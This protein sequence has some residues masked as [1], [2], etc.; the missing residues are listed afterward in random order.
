MTANA[1]DS[2][3]PKELPGITQRK[4]GAIFTR[5]ELRMLNERS[6]WRGLAAVGFTW[7]VILATAAALVWARSQPALIAVPVFVLGLAVLGGRHLGLAVLHHEAAHRSLFKTPW[8]NEVVGD[9]V[10]A[11]PVWNDLKK[12]RVHHFIHHRKT[13]QPEDTDRSL[14]EPFPTTRASLARKLGRDLVGITG[15]KYL[16][17]HMLMDAGVLK[18]TVASDL[19]WL[20]RNGRRW[21][22]YPLEFLRNAGGMLLVNALLL[23]ACFAS[24]HT[25]LYSVWVLS[26]VTPYPLFVRVRSLA[27]HACTATT[28]DMFLNTRTTR[29]G[30]LA[31]ATVAP[32]RVNYHVEHHVLPGVAY[33]RLPLMHR[34][35]RERGVVGEPPGYL[36]VLTIVSSRRALAGH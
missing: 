32:V 26:Y 7:A 1:L 2:A 8:L 12:Y 11:R 3:T 15:L 24:G 6:D 25:W 5:D 4:I 21:W 17:G 16:V 20:P 18:W 34:M 35:L 29:A 10:C 9:W 36:D 28:T 14:V 27:E 19:V 13:S 23:A 22:S 30:L 31:R 33:Y